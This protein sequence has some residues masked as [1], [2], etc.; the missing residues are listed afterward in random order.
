MYILLFDDNYY[1]SHKIGKDDVSMNPRNYSEHMHSEYEIVYLL[2]GSAQYTVEQCVYNLHPNELML[3]RPG[4]H[5]QVQVDNWEDYERIVINFASEDIP[6]Y[7]LAGLENRSGVYDIEGTYLSQLLLKLDDHYHAVSGKIRNELM[8][9]SLIQILI[10]LCYCESKVPNEETLNENLAKVLAY[11]SK[12]LTK[13]HTISDITQSCGMSKSY[14]CKLF[15]EY[16][17]VPVMVY[18]RT[19]KCMMAKTLIQK[20]ERPTGI[21]EKCGYKSYSSFFRAYCRANMQS[22]A[23]MKRRNN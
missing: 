9:T 13:I 7:I 22:P 17:H 4:E 20:G 12:N 15:N 8:R 19:K 21:Y 14:L 6:D 11:I 3:I 18:V 10:Y 16:M 2:S 1:F 5:H 23:E